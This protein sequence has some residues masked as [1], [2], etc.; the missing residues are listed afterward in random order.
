M[1]SLAAAHAAT[2]KKL[3]EIP[4]FGLSLRIN[5]IKASA[6]G[7]A[8]VY[9]IPVHGHILITAEEAQAFAV[10]TVRSQT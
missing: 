8:G 5:E 1:S 9:V 3:S 6:T 2:E 7:P 10:P 4:V